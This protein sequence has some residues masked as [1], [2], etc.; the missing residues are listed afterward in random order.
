[1]KTKSGKELHR[2]G[3]GTWGIASRVNTG[4]EN[5]YGHVEAIHGNE[6]EEIAAIQYSL[7]KGQNHIDCAEL[8]GAFYT[9]DVVGTAIAGHDREDLYIADKL[10]KTSIEDRRVRLTVERMLKKLQTNY[11]D[12]LYIH[13][14]WDDV[15]WRMAIPQIDSLIGE[16][17]V[18]EF[19]VS[20]FT[21]EQMQVA[22]D[23][24][25][26]PVAAN[27][28]HYNVI[29]QGNADT[30]FR[31]FC[32]AHDIQIVAYQP[33]KRTAVMESPIIQ[34]IAQSHKATPSQVALAWLIQ[35]GTLPI[36]KATSHEHID[37]NLG[38]L[39]IQLTGEEIAALSP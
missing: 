23:I 32:R 20:N 27:Q 29:D 7:S 35:M 17:V 3:I 24:A 39:E 21:V 30:V 36:P 37:E 22:M 16:G 10:W 26:H 38:A 14:P 9:D 6:P 15:D 34:D 33:L 19:G 31:D 2:V 1:M 4:V 25:K 28:I 12:L 5:K 13:S 11:I 8:Y 18:R